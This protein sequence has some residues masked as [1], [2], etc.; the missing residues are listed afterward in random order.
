VGRGVI[1]HTTVL[2]LSF[3][4]LQLEDRSGPRRCRQMLMRTLDVA[5]ARF[6]RWAKASRASSAGSSGS[7]LQARRL[8]GPSG[9]TKRPE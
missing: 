3:S 8:G 7:A 6:R 5:D 9:R 2:A 1:K 4:A